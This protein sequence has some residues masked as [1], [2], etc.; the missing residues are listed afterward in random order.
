VKDIN[1]ADYTRDYDDLIHMRILEREIDI[2]K[3]R[4]TDFDTG[5]LRTA[6]S[7]LER[8]VDELENNIREKL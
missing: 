5:N 4:Y 8:R 6:V 3:G 1:M 2:I 7:V